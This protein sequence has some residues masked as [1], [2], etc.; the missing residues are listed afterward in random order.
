MRLESFN[1]KLVFFAGAFAA[2]T[3]LFLFVNFNIDLP[4]KLGKKKIDD[5]KN[6]IVSIVHGLFALLVSGYHIYRD[7]PQYT[8]PSQNIQHI[9][10]LTSLSYF[11]Y[12]FIAC[13]YYGLC[14][15]PLV[16]H[17]G[18][19]LL[20]IG[21]S[22]LT[23]NGTCALFGIFFAEVSNFPMHF[24][25][26][27]RTFGMRYTKMYELSEALY[28]ISYIV[29]RGMGITYVVFTAT[30][31][32]EIPIIVRFTCLGLWVQSLYFIYEMN[33]ILQRKLKYY[34]ERCQKNVSYCWFGESSKLSELSYFRQEGKEKIF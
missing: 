11:L 3:T 4:S 34:N 7:N 31:V 25:C 30:L 32:S 6:R 13:V 22:E 19:C 24:R 2:W 9:I 1:D 5:T 18:M 16:L 14:D 33:G 21:L 27:L 12:D 20:G 26:I 10:M 29:A 28:I 23:N 17:H 8:E 15:L